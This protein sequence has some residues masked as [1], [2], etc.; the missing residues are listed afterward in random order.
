MPRV[1]DCQPPPNGPNGSPG[2][3]RTE[4]LPTAKDGASG[5]PVVAVFAD[6]PEL[7]TRPTFGWMSSVLHSAELDYASEDPQSCMTKLAWLQRIA[8][9]AALPVNDGTDDATA[10][11]NSSAITARIRAILRNIRLGLDSYGRALNHVSLLAPQALS[12]DI[13]REIDNAND[14]E[15]TLKDLKN[16]Q[17]GQNDKINNIQKAGDALHQI[18]ALRQAQIQKLQADAAD[19]MSQIDALRDQLNELW[20][21]LQ[22]ADVRFRQAV[23][24]KAGCSFEDIC[25]CVALVTTV[26]ATAGA[27]AAA[28]T[29]AGPAL[30]T[31]SKL[32]ETEDAGGLQQQFETISKAVKPLG[33]SA[34][35][36]KSSYGAAK[37]LIAKYR[38]Q[39]HNPP[40]ATDISSDYVKLSTSSAEFDTAIQPYLALPEAQAYKQLMHTFVATSQAR[41]NKVVEHDAIVAQILQ[42]YT[43]IDLAEGRRNQLASTTL[44]TYDAALDHNVSYLDSSLT[45]VKSSIIKRVIDLQRSVEYMTGEHREIGFDD[46]SVGSLEVSADNATEAYTDA[47]DA[48]GQAPQGAEK[49]VL[50]L[51]PL[52]TRADQVRFAAGKQVL[53]VIPADVSVFAGYYAVQTRRL[54][55]ARRDTTRLPGTL[56]IVFEHQGH[57][58]VFGRDRTRHV[59]THVKV[60]GDFTQDPNNVNSP[61]TLVNPS[62]AT[63]FVG[64]SPFG[65]WVIQLRAADPQAK[66]AL[67]QAY[68]EFDITKRVYPPGA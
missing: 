6:Y 26:V 23:G 61:G 37:E 62:D 16:R 50:P 21:Q 24:A 13:K 44:Q 35:E 65:P 22:S 39:D 51:W 30:A 64:V 36:F 28:L 47:M 41:N 8:T 56:S 54:G 20:A 67:S 49:I 15:K 11:K 45:N 17:A 58:L 42:A 12:A 68:L 33:T 59:Y 48:F 43:D 53:L 60:V 66:E 52:L 32:N 29:A 7:F 63:R 57:S 4:P 19:T 2:A 46:S 9:A 40:P 31:L 38:S 5:T 18:G 3:P 10:R 1:A 55:F 25:R 34:D 14:M 27:G